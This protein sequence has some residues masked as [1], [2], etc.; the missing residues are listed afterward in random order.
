ME[1]KINFYEETIQVLNSIKCTEKDIMYLTDGKN[2]QIWKD[3]KEKF[4]KINY[5]NGYGINLINIGLKIILKDYILIREEYDGS[6]W[7][8]AIKRN[9]DELSYS[10]LK[11]LEDY[12]PTEDIEILGDKMNI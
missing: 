4:K 1:K 7:W 9:Y 6:E 11:I 2:I 8:K 12:L 10:E 3:V 5:Y